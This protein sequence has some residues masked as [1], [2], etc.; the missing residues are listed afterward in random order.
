M[1]LFDDTISAISTPRGEGGIGIVRVSGSKA[2]QIAK[3]LFRVPSK[4]GLSKLKTLESYTLNYGFVVNPET[5][6]VVDEILLGVMKAPRSYTKEDVIEF[7]CHGGDLPLRKTLELTL[8]MG[9]RLA[10]PGEFTKRAFINGRID[11]AQAEAVIDLIRSKTDLSRKVAVNQL[12]GKLS[13]RIG[14]LRN[15]LVRILAEVEASIDFPGE[16]LNFMDLDEMQTRAMTVLEGIS[17]MIDSADQGRILREGVDV[18]IVGRPNVGK[19]SLLNALLQQERAIVT[20]VPGTTRDTIEEYI[21]IDGIPLKLTDTAGISQTADVVEQAGIERA[22]A[23]LE[24]SELLLAM[25]DVSQPLEEDDIRLLDLCKDQLRRS[26]KAVVLILNKIDLPK[27]VSPIQI[28][29][30]LPNRPIVKT[31]M[32]T[33]VG[34]DELK[35]TIVDILTSGDIVLSDSVMITNLRH[36]NALKKAKKSLEQ[37]LQTLMDGM[38]PELVAVDLRGALD[39]LGIIIGKTTTDDILDRIF[40]QFCV[41][42]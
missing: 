10:E 23:L 17:K 20:E 3:H 32:L 1:E 29:E 16:D 19:S 34:L 25:F 36:L 39:E 42:K 24:R 8:N 4:N 12:S 14:E 35:S 7:N 33:E 26:K 40:S 15:S 41:G 38:P 2:I 11:L 37:A 27:V 21:N 13:E 31:S 9:A 22:K 5:E 28:K 30:H 6:E 18:A